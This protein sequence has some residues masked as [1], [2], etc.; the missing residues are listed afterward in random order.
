[1]KRYYMCYDSDQIVCGSNEHVY[2]FASSLKTAKQYINRCCKEKAEYNPHNF[3]IY[4]TYSD[5]DP[6]TGY[7]PCVYQIEQ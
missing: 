2:G 7:V 6:K 5:L 1:M 4:D 3:R